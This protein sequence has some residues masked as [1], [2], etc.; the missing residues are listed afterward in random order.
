MVTD[1]L[2]MDINKDG[3]K[4]LVVVGQFMPIIILKTITNT[5]AGNKG[6]WLVRD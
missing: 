6:V 5:K 1:A 3:W 4:D 2:W